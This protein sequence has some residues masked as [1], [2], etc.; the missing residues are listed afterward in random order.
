MTSFKCR[1]CE[2]HWNEGQTCDH[3]I[4]QLCRECLNHK[5]KVC[6]ADAIRASNEGTGEAA[7]SALSTILLTTE[8]AIMGIGF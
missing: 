3:R 7:Q 4:D 5:L 8:N 2:N 1:E 6:H